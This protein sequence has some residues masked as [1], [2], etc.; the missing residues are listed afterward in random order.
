MTRNGFLGL[1]GLGVIAAGVAKTLPP[2]PA[3]TGAQPY[4]SFWETM[5]ANTATDLR[6]HGRPE[7]LISPEDVQ[8]IVA[9]A[10][11]FDAERA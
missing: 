8:A 9:Q 3:V 2:D 11:A 6:W 10:R 5:Q 4:R 1:L 7:A